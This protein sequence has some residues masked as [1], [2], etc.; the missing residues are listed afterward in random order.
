[1]AQNLQF[2]TAKN[3][4]KMALTNERGKLKNLEN[5]RCASEGLVGE[6][7]SF[8]SRR[9]KVLAHPLG[10]WRQKPQTIGIHTPRPGATKTNFSWRRIKF[11]AAGK[12]GKRDCCECWR[13]AGRRN[14]SV[15]NHRNEL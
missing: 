7:A 15:V 10:C 8:C 1:M 13:F 5:K 11:A 4:S 3:I 6:R 14:E 9:K 12:A 2:K